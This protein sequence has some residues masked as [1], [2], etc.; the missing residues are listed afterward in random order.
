MLQRFGITL[1]TDGSERT[2]FA[3]RRGAVSVKLLTKIPERL[4]V[5]ATPMPS[6][7]PDSDF[8]VAVV[9]EDG[10]QRI[11]TIHGKCP[12]WVLDAHMIPPDAVMVAAPHQ[13]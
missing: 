2:V 3:S 13:Y 12:D 1:A 4:I 6:F 5:L 10:E 7:D 9:N 8:I 11:D